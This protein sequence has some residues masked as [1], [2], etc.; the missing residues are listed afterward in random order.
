MGKIK[1]VWQ[2]WLQQEEEWI[3][4]AGYKGVRNNMEDDEGFQYEPNVKYAIDG[5][6]SRHNSFKFSLSIEDVDKH[7]CWCDKHNRYFR[8]MAFVRASEFERYN[9]DGLTELHAK[10]IVLKDEITCSEEIFNYVMTRGYRSAFRSETPQDIRNVWEAGPDEYVPCKYAELM[11]DDYYSK[12]FA[13]VFVKKV[14]DIYVTNNP[15]SV[16]LRYVTEAIKA[17]NALAEE[18]VSKDMAVYLLMKNL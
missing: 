8:V 12:A 15:Y 11:N 18:H 14:Y 3:W 16:V 9:E 2:K 17:A 10:Q 4:V 13:C 5:R 1:T 7:Y 6:F